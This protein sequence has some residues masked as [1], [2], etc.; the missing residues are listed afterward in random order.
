MDGVGVD[1]V[2]GDLPYLR[3]VRRRN[4]G[5]LDVGRGQIG[6]VNRSRSTGWTYGYRMT[7]WAAGLAGTASRPRFACILPN[8]SK[9]DEFISS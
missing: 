5:D 1:S 4:R 3:A 7:F 2:V 8:S 9:L 6:G